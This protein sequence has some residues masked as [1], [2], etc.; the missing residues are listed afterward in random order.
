MNTT[1]ITKL[2]EEQCFCDLFDDGSEESF[3]GFIT[4]YSDSLIQIDLF[5]EEG[6]F[7]GVLILQ[8]DDVSRIR[9][10]SREIE[11]TQKLVGERLETSKIDLQSLRTAA[12]DL[13]SHFGYIA[14]TLG[15]H[16]S[17]LMLIGE[18]EN[19]DD[20]F[21]LLHEYGTRAR[22]D[23]SHCIVRWSDITRIQAGGT[24]EK[25]LHQH[26]RKSEQGACTQPSVA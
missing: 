26:Y 23:R 8:I 12:H 18:I 4:G 3:Y 24:Y 11:L 22:D 6:R 13:S 25:N 15:A 1:L 5:D 19:E 21:L 17:E 2:I 7:D 20:H 10:G 14:V 16:D 9:W